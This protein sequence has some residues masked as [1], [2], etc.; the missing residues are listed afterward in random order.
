MCC[1]QVPYLINNA[2]LIRRGP[3]TNF[4]HN[5][6]GVAS[7]HG[8][9]SLFD[10]EVAWRWGAILLMT[11]RKIPKGF[12]TFL[13]HLCQATTAPCSIID[14]LPARPNF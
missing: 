7:M 10:Q 2:H 4:Q 9:E 3:K 11:H 12:L 5:C 13:Q 6:N 14:A 1:F 8:V